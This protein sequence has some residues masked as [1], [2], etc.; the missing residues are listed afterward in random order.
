MLKSG[1]AAELTC[2]QVTG[3]I[4]AQVPGLVFACCGVVTLV[5]VW[6]HVIYHIYRR[7]AVL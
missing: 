1:H 2:W 3:L 5:H 4:P 7:I 6:T